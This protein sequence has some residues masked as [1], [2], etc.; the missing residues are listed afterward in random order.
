MVSCSFPGCPD[1]AEHTHHITYDPSVTKPL[2]RKHHEDITIINGQQAR[3]NR[4][5]RNWRE[6]Q[7][8]RLS[9]KHRWWIWFQWLNGT[10]K[11]RRTKKALEWL[12]DW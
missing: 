7:Y 3:K 8:L 10:L 9:N 11:P 6:S 4:R 5:K 2:C 12:K 1:P